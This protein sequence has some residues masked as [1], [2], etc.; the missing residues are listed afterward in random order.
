M[1]MKTNEIIGTVIS[2]IGFCCILATASAVEFQEPIAMTIGQLLAL[3]GVGFS[4]LG[5][6]VYVINW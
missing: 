2:F 4:I 1:K 3:G 5:F 6:G